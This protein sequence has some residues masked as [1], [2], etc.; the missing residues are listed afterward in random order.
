MARR[1]KLVTAGDVMDATCR[2]AKRVWRR[3]RV[4]NDFNITDAPTAT[5]TAQQIINAFQTTP[6]YLLRDR[7]SIYGSISVQRVAGMGIQQQLIASRS[8]WQPLHGAV[9]G[10]DSARMPRSI[11]RVQR[12]AV[13]TRPP[14]L[15]RILP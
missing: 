11:D 13:E 8:P 7:D 5:W 14:I 6:E 9:G 10:F 2:Q 12:T 4:E 3:Y 15:L 1:I